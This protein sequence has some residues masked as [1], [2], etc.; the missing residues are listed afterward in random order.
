MDL[1]R[2]Q[3]P[4]DLGLG[5]HHVDVMARNQTLLVEVRDER[6]PALV[7]HDPLQIE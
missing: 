6:P 1:W 3:L 4:A 7:R 2:V 5:V